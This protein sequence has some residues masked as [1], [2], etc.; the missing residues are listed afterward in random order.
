MKDVITIYQQNKHH[1]SHTNESLVMRVS[2]PLNVND[3]SVVWIHGRRFLRGGKRLSGQ[4]PR[5]GT[6][7]G[8]HSSGAHWKGAVLMRTLAQS[9]QTVLLIGIQI[10]LGWWVVIVVIV[11]VVTRRWG[12]AIDS[13]AVSRVVGRLGG[14]GV[15]G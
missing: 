11:N 14:M 9:H 6:V 8:H 4:R 3:R 2:E 13:A 10:S 1:F 15:T 12:L 5:R 7:T